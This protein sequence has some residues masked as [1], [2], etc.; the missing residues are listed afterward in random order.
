MSA[1]VIE[2]QR[3]ALDKAVSI[4]DLLRKALV[5]SRKLKLDKFEEWIGYELNG[6]VSTDQVPHY[7]KIRGQVGYNN[8]YHGWSPITFEDANEEDAYS[9]RNST[10]SVAELENIIGNN[11]EK[12]VVAMTFSS[13]YEKPLL[14]VTFGHKPYLR[15]SRSA[16]IGIL[17]A[18]RNNVLKWSLSLEEEGILG[19]E[20]SFSESEKQRA[21]SISYHVNNF[22]AP[23]S[24]SQFSQDAHNPVQVV[25]SSSIDIRAIEGML[26]D[27]KGILNSITLASD[28]RL[29]LD[30][31][32]ATVESQLKSP[33]PK[34]LILEHSFQSIYNILEHAGGHVISAI[35]FELGKVITGLG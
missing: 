13:R 12:S 10:Q 28:Q 19:E 22:F 34:P 6:Y 9:S 32:I 23:V 24:Q 30:S 21:E 3:D 14:E 11:D 17:D 18:V 35:L 31:E 15:I 1:I 4:S 25:N 26:S 33:K 5:V 7:R 29:E 16:I 27:I 8:P 20:L 2:L